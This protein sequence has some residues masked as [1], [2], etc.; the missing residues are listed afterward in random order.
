MIENQSQANQ[1]GARRK[2]RLDSHNA[3]DSKKG[4]A[5]QKPSSGGDAKDGWAWKR[6]TDKA[7]KI[8]VL[9]EIDQLEKK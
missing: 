7:K 2:E 4:S 3:P 5:R 8:E 1:T 6:K 9:R